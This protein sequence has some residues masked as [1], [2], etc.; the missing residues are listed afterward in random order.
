MINRLL[1]SLV[2]T[3][4][5]LGF[6]INNVFANHLPAA[7][8]TW[9]CDPSNPLE[10]NVTLEIY[11]TCPGVLFGSMNNVTTITNSCGLANPIAPRWYVVGTPIEVNQLCPSA[12]S[13]CSGGSDPSFWLYT[14]KLSVGWPDTTVTLPGDCDNW[15]IEF[16]FCC[17][18]G[19][20]NLYT[21][22]PGNS[23]INMMG[24]SAT[25]NTL[26]APCNNS[27]T[28]TSA[29]IPY[30]CAGIN[31]NHCIA[32]QDIDGDS[33]S[34]AMVNPE[35][36]FVGSPITHF[37]PYTAA[38]PLTGF[39]LD[40]VTGCF[41]FN[42]PTVG[43]YVVAIQINSY[44]AAGQLIGSF[45]Y[46]FQVVVRA[47]SNTPPINPPSGISSFSGTGTQVNSNTV[48]ACLGESICFNVIFRDFPIA[49]GDIVTVIQD[50]TTLFP[51][52]TFTQTGTNPVTGTFCWVAQAGYSGGVVTFTANDDACPI[53]GVTSF[54]VNIIYSTCLVLPIT[55]TSFGGYN[56]GQY[57]SLNWS[58]G[59]E[60]N[61][62][63]FTLERSKDGVTFEE[64]GEVDGSGNSSVVNNYAFIDKSPYTGVN[65]Y[66]LKQ[67][68]FDYN[69]SYS[70]LV[71]IEVSKGRE[72]SIYPNPSTSFVKLSYGDKSLLNAVI[73]VYDVQGKLVF[74]ETVKEDNISHEININQLNNGLYFMIVNSGEG[75][76]K[77]TFLKK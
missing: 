23:G 18:N 61:N 42:E 6:N 25:L 56:S 73:K 26:T 46:D 34:F 69:Y 33:V 14:Y 55:L 27:P 58:T 17:R 52:S 45:P 47:C 44:N 50:G 68:D 20:T 67:T 41:T 38:V 22:T 21:N 66:R 63:Y 59:S 28:V 71:A 29:P 54:A 40:P 2:L 77:A 32:T 24:V 9:T 3:S 53:M 12:T 11:R 43:D 1:I 5:F 36:T 48:S 75:S 37:A 10:Y 30:A 39:V 74:E 7:N 57:N 15:K 72:L 13:S 62:D 60:I 16:E 51:N 65:Y 76:L 31:F 8:I 49:G 35:G 19:P 64:I 70:D 4:F